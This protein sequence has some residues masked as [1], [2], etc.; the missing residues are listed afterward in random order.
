METR[1]ERGWL[2][3]LRLLRLGAGERGQKRFLR[4]GE[5]PSA[6]PG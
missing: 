3:L 1:L 5:G 2:A 4:L 6:E